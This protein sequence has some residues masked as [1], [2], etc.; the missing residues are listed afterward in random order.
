MMGGG[1]KPSLRNAFQAF[2]NR[3][4]RFLFASSF[5]SFIG[6][7]M[8]M[9]GRGLLAWELTGSFA[10][11]GLLGIS[12]GLP[13]LILSPFGGATA[14]RFEKRQMMV[15]ARFV[16]GV[17]A[18]LTAV[19]IITGVISVPI[20]F[21]LGLVQGTMFAFMMPA[22][23]AVHRPG[24]EHHDDDLQHDADD[25][26]ADRDLRRPRRRKHRVH[27]D[28]LYRAGLFRRHRDREAQ[29]HSLT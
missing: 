20:L 19:F 16:S 6:M 11:T 25:G 2:D 5:A 7:Q 9:V 15:I 23:Q 13:M 8:M 4:F 28:G 1:G 17:I 29:L 27:V 10:T 18:A 14:D 21:A 12:F 26:L 3:N 22:Q 24:D